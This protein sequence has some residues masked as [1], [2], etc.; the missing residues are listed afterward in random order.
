M[1]FHGNR[2]TSAPTELCEAGGW[3]TDGKI[4]D[5][6]PF[7]NGPYGVVR[8]LELVRRRGEIVETTP[9]P[10]CVGPPP[11]ARGGKESLCKQRGYLLFSAPS[12]EG[13]GAE[14][15]RESAT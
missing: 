11:L 7:V 12:V 14:R 8:I 4:V 2:E 5:N 9:P 1:P 13:A 10:T 15:L 3:R 6:G